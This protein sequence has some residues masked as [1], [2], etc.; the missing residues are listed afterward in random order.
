VVPKGCG[1]RA[2]PRVWK[3]AVLPRQGSGPRCQTAAKNGSA[4]G[5]GSSIGGE[6]AL[7]VQV[8]FA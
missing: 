8:I 1:T 4:M 7:G 2:R 6:E 5:C 3:E